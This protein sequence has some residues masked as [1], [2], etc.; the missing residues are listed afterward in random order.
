MLSHRSII[1]SR[2][3]PTTADKFLTTSSFRPHPPSPKYDKL[4]SECGFKI[5]IVGFGGGAPI[6][7]EGVALEFFFGNSLTCDDVLDWHGGIL[8]HPRRP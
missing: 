1:I 8:P 5:Y 2:I 3:A 6:G 4:K 7:A